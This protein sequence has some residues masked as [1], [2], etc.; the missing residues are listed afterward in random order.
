MRKI[1][2]PLVAA[3][4]FFAFTIPA[5]A[6]P[7]SDVPSDHWAYRAVNHLQQE[8]I[9]VGYPD[10][11][12][13]GDNLFTRYEMAMV[14]AR[15]YDQLM[16]AIEDIEV[17]FPDD[18]AS[19][20]ELEDLKDYVDDLLDEFADELEMIGYDIDDM[21]DWMWNIEDRV[22]ALEKKTQA[23][24]VSGALRV[25]IED[26]ITNEYMGP[27]G[28]PF[29]GGTPGTTPPENFEFEELIKLAFKAQ[30]APFITTYIDM[31]QVRS[32]IGSGGVGGMTTATDNGYLAIDQAYIMTDVFDILGWEPGNM[33]N[34][35]NVG[36][37]RMYATYGQYGMIF[38]NHYRTRPAISF[39]TGGDRLDIKA[40]MARNIRNNMQE[41]LGI[42]RIAYGFGD[43]KC[44]YNRT[45]YFAKVG[46]NLLVEGYGDEDG[47]G[48]DI[49]TE[50][51]SGDY[52]NHGKV[53]YV[54]MQ[55]DQ[56]GYSV[57]DTYGTDYANSFI[58]GVD[59]F[60]NGNTKMTVQ[61]A[62][63]GLLPGFTSAD[64]NPFEEWDNYTGIIGGNTH[65]TYETGRN[66]FPINFVGAGAIIEHTWFDTLYTKLTFYDGKTQSE[67]H[68]PALIRLHLK[69][70]LSDKADIMLDY[71]HSGIDAPTLA[72]L[73]GTFLVSF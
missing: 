61:Y 55:K 47:I 19:K 45:N 38:D 58:V 50:I 21:K 13:K 59:L 28:S 22:T 37:G 72:K 1:L 51:L 25:K 6:G 17:N 2:I 16:E 36:A 62:D 9:I 65:L 46:V 68:L 67:S 15:I 14:I 66:I 26:I 53:E 31:W 23:V 20:A 3:F 70:P 39:D 41:G 43:P 11:T 29:I 56:M 69:Y 42:G 57:D 33:F 32:F 52:L 12:F 27:Y 49:D 7:F 35:F 48:F 8:G 60:N 71:I 4:L 40:F 44:E 34:R 18:Y 30:P 73:R 24:H 10:G 5:F 54:Y 64:L 63:I